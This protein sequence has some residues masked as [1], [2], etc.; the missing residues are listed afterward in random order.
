[1]KAI[2]IILAVAFIALLVGFAVF[3]VA[4][5]ANGWD[6]S[7]LSSVE[8]KEEVYREKTGG[9]I[10]TVVIKFDN[11]DIKVI[12]GDEFSVKYPVKYTKANKQVTKIILRDDGG[13]LYVEEKRDLFRLIFGGLFDFTDP[14]LEITVPGERAVSL[15]LDTDNGD[16]R[17]A[18]NEKTIFKDIKI[19]CDNSDTVIKNV[20]AESIAFEADNGEL[21]L[22]NVTVSG[23]I[24]IETSNGDVE[25]KGKVSAEK[26][27]LDTDN[28]EIGEENGVVDAK[29][30]DIE[31][32]NGDVEIKLVGKAEDYS[33]TVKTDNGDK[34]ISNS[35]GGDR[36]LNIRTDNGDVE[37]NF[38]N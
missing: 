36:I 10:K 29:N 26:I 33:V 25:F 2:K 11:A 8:I 13:I 37:V 34:N 4:L 9:D 22:E 19:E 3:M 21:L 12:E 16:V 27:K 28:G 32:D 30:I 35:S 17:I 14:V 38:I 15:D 24:N 31:T 20:S 6:V 18:G 5:A 1:M 23:A 7:R